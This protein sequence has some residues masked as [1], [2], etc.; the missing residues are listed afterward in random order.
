MY[1]TVI[2]GET[3]S[4]KSSIAKEIVKKSGH[5]N[6][7]DV[8]NEYGLKAYPGDR[9]RFCL[10]PPKHNIKHFI[11]VVQNTTGFL[12]VIEEGTGVFKG[13]VGKEFIGEILGKRHTGNRFVLIF[14]QLHRIPPDLYEFID[15]LVMF[16]TG[17]LEKNIKSKYPDLLDRFRMLQYSRKKVLEPGGKYQISEYIV[18]NRTNLSQKINGNTQ[19]NIPPSV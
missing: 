17:D 14:H 3:G 19:S 11:K 15:V 13:T 12:H 9:K 10:S 16:R 1:L 5:V 8:Q 6:V 4:G 7:Y 18:V 2:C